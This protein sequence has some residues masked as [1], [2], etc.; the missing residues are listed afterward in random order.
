MK[1]LRIAMVL[2]GLGRVQRGAEAAFLELTRQLTAYPDLHVELFGTGTKGPPGVPLHQLGCVPRER[3]EGWPRLPC[4]RSEY[5][6]EELTFVLSLAWRRRF[7]PRDFDVVVSCS[8]PFVNWFLRRRR[9][10][11]RPVHVFVTQN[12]DWMCR[13]QGR[14]YRFFHCDGLVCTN[15]E[16]YARHRGRYRS[17]L[18]PNGVDARVFHPAGA[19]AEQV[20]TPTLPPASAGRPVVLMASALIPSKAVGDGIRAVAGVPGAFLAVA[21][22]GPQRAEVA[23]QAAQ[24]LPG[25]H[26]LLGGVPREQMPALFRRADAFLHMSRDEPF[27]LVYLEAASTGLPVVAH[28]GE[29]PRWVLGDAALYVDTRNPAAVSPALRQALDPA[30]GKVLG[31]RARERVLS[32]WTWEREAAEYRAFF[33]DLAGG[34]VAASEA[35]V[36]TGG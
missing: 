16:Y 18:I 29:V 22:D 32:G 19:T 25:R 5:E 27:G 21:G 11:G 31:R 8:Y 34:R 36:A 1:K 9:P 12:G 23:G 30:V 6:Y 35:A 13:A 10:R 2:A 28:D 26:A 15:P 20:P 24:H 14:E 33:Y 4:L 17:M 3:F 7:R